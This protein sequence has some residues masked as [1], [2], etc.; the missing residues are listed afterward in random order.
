[1]SKVIAPAKAQVSPLQPAQARAEHGRKILYVTATLPYGA[2]E[3]FLIPEVKELLRRGCD[4]RIVPR[5]PTYRLVHKNAADLLEHCTAKPVF[6]WDVAKGA[7]KELFLR[8][9]GA[10]RA[11][12]V[13]FGN[14]NWTNLA[15]N[16]AGYAKG[17]WLGGLAR[18]WRAD[19]IHALWISTPATM[20]MIASIVSQ[21][22][23]SCTAHRADIDLNNLLAEK[24]KQARMVRFISQ[25]GWRMAASLGAPPDPRNAA[26]MHL[27]VNLPSE[28]EISSSPGPRGTI[29]CPAHL[30]P[31]KGHRYLIEAV[32]LLR[33]RGVECKLLLAGDGEL[34]SELEALVQGLGLA[35]A[36]DFLGQRSHSEILAM[37]REGR[38]GQV[39]LP[40]VDLGHNLHEGIPVGLIEAMSYNIPVVGTRTGGIPELLE[41]GAGL[42]VPDKDPLALADAIERYVRDPAFTADVS[43]K[44]RQRVFESFNVETVVSQLLE[45]ILPA[46]VSPE[47]S[48]MPAPSKGEE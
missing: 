28:A 31:V 9:R 42:I 15:K 34:R 33:K 48:R 37:Y 12:A 17:L 2:G 29:L 39:V 47:N 21:T 13:L 23:W 8:P 43:A 14:S 24:L 11:L 18:N 36:V 38:V 16:L 10:F 44:G 3:A 1:M 25:S 22:P 27:G 6:G 30:Y 35:D 4:V 41:G 45:R 26:V 20:G 19:H 32:A 5:S 7:L 46:Q 40:S